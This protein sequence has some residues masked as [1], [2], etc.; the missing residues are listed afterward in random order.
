MTVLALSVLAFPWLQVCAS[1]AVR[2]HEENGGKEED[3]GHD[4]C[5]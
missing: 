1:M 2:T 5:E 3:G 4:D